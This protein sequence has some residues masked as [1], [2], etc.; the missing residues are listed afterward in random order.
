MTTKIVATYT[1][2]Q[3]SERLDRIARDLYGSERGGTTEGLLTANRRLSGD[4][5]DPEGDTA[6]GTILSVPQAPETDEEEIVRP[7]D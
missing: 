3:D 5:K 2:T 4:L 7:W 6:F 1:V